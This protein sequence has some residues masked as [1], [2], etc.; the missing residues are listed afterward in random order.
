M[1]YLC[2]K[3]G[4]CSFSRFGFIVHTNRQTDRHTHRQ[5]HRQTDRITD[6]NKRFTLVT[7]V[8]VSNN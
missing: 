8:G 7:V 4:D 5:T 2:V 6:A 1:D 3:F